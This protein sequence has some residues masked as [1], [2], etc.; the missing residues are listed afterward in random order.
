MVET[1]SLAE[2]RRR[3]VLASAVVGAIAVLAPPGANAAGGRPFAAFVGEWTG[4]G[5]VVGANGSSERIRCRASG[6]ESSDG[7]GLTQSIVCASPG[8]RIDIQSEVEA[9]G[10]DVTGT[11]SEQTRGA[12]GEL[13]GTIS[14]GQFEGSVRGPNFTANVL[15]R[16]NGRVQTVKIAP[17]GAD[18]A[19]VRLELKRRE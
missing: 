13:T 5:V 9:A 7:A 6:A 18:I 12:S 3:V 19:E 2:R 15:L 4:G 14:G 16:A 17:T 10:R 8:Y 1:V 11:W